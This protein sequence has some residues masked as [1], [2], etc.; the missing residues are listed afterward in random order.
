MAAVAAAAIDI[1]I[2]YSSCMYILL[3]P[4]Q[5]K[6]N[7]HGMRAQSVGHIKIAFLLFWLFNGIV[8]KSKSAALLTTLYASI[9]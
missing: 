8:I 9:V 7:K 3:Q 6:W 5:R 1:S 4:L 2:D